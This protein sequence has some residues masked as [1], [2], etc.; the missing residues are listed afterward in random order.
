MENGQHILLGSDAHFYTGIGD[1]FYAVAL[2]EK[3]GFPEGLVLNTQ[4]EE[5]Q[6]HL[7]HR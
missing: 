7:K 3:I 5:I 1:V 2:L 6:K 4:P